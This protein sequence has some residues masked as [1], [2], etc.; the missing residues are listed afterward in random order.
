[1]PIPRQRCQKL[2]VINLVFASVRITCR[3]VTSNFQGR[4]L[5]KLQ[6]F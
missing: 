4:S 2:D 1:M 6:W 3:K 5:K